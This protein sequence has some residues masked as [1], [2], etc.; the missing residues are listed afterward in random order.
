M[1]FPLTTVEDMVRVQFLLIEHL[2][3]DRVHASV[4]SSLGGMQAILGAALFPERVGR[5]ALTVSL[6]NSHTWM[7]S[8][9]RYI[10]HIHGCSHCVAM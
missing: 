3:I 9:C 6:Y 2:G 8:L 4:G 10:T 5:Y 1:S 7:L